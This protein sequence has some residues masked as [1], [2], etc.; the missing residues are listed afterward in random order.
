MNWIE[1]EGK[2]LNQMFLENLKFELFEDG[3]SVILELTCLI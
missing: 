2:G 3:K 1:K